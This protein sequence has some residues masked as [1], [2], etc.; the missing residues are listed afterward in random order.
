MHATCWMELPTANFLSIGSVCIARGPFGG[1]LKST[2][3]AI[4]RSCATVRA[5]LS[6]QALGEEAQL[7]RPAASAASFRKLVAT[8]TNPATANKSKG[9]HMPLPVGYTKMCILTSYHCKPPVA[10]MAPNFSKLVSRSRKLVSRWKHALTSRE[11]AL[12]SRMH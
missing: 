12:T 4:M 1:R 9:S 2:H 5:A 6:K 11:H 7:D 8:D 10:I 3:D